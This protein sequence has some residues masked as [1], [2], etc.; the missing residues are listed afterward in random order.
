MTE[1]S[2]FQ[3]VRAAREAFA[4]AHGFDVH[5]IVADL[6]KLDRTGDRKVVRLPPRRPQAVEAK[7]NGNQNQ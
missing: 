6:Q 7:P 4:Q 2:V 1:D 3:E 5:R